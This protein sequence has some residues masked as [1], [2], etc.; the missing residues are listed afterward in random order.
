MNYGLHL[1]ASGILTNMHRQDVIANNLANADTAGFKRDLMTFSQRLPEAREDPAPMGMSDELM[2][3]LGGGVLAAPSR[4]DLRDGAA[5]E[6]G[7]PLD[8][9]LTGPGF[10]AVQVDDGQSSNTQLTRDGRLTLTEGGDLVTT[11]GGHRVLDDQ[12]QPITLDPAAEVRIDQGGVIRQHGAPVATLARIATPG[13]PEP[14]HL[15]QGLYSAEPEQL[16]RPATAETRV[17]Q[18]FVEQS[19]VDPVREMVSMI[20]STRAINNNANLMR[21]HDTIMEQAAT[22]LGRIN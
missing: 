22:V 4:L 14:R 10:F 2:N 16:T 8:I 6:T 12:L 11:T 5:R 20:E 1:S 19:N 13:D 7:N 9:A 18:G 3:R 17:V 21:I 15:G